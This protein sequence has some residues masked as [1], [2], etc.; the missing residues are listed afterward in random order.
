MMNNSSVTLSNDLGD[1]H[2][3][4]DACFET[5]LRSNVKAPVK[6]RVNKDKECLV[7]LNGLQMQN[8]GIASDSGK[9]WPTN[10]D[11]QGY[12]T[13]GSSPH[14]QD[15]SEN[16]LAAPK[17]LFY[18]D[19]SFGM[20]ESQ[21]EVDCTKDQDVPAVDNRRSRASCIPLPHENNAGPDSAN[22]SDQ[23]VEIDS[24]S[25]CGSIFS[26]A[27][28]KGKLN[29]TFRLTRHQEST[30]VFGSQSILALKGVKTHSSAIALQGLRNKYPLLNR[31]HSSHTSKHNHNVD[32]IF[33]H[34]ANISPYMRR[35]RVRDDTS[36]MGSPTCMQSPTDTV[37]WTR[38]SINFK[39]IKD[40][41]L[42]QGDNYAIIGDGGIQDTNLLKELFKCPQIILALFSVFLITTEIFRM[43]LV[44]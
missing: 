36:T 17:V 32:H 31:T 30:P 16:R 11:N 25:D 6:Y 5:D 28:S 42:S 24:N 14:G 10:T 41:C 2:A 21:N 39:K 34:G 8:S 13:L 3:S 4:M 23:K 12:S 33:D 1:I 43:I 19:G 35:C 38:R 26:S 40:G 44:Q 27:G 22:K 15:I 29:K 7:T 9:R 20:S 37:Y 18:R